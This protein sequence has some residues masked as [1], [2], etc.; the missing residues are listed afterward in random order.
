MAQDNTF[1][2]SLKDYYV[3]LSPLAY[4]DSL[5][6]KGNS[7]HASVMQNVDVLGE[8]MTQGPGL[9]NLTNG[10]QAGA[11]TE[12]INFILDKAV[13]SDV[14]YG[15]G[16]TKLFKIS[17]TAVT[18]DATF[19]HAITNCTNGESVIDMGGNLY[20]FYNKASGGEIGKYDLSSTFDDDWG[21]TTP[22]GAAAIQKAVHPSA[23]KEDII[24]FGNGQYVG[25]YI[26]GS[27]TLD[28]DKLDFGS[29]NEVADVVFSGNQWMIAVNSGVTGTNRNIGQIYLYD[30]GALSS[31]LS[32]EA[33]VGFQKIGWLYELNGIVYVAYQD[34]SSTGYTIGYISGR[35][36]KPLAHFTGSLP[37]F[38]QKTLYKHTI[39]FLS[40][41]AVWSAGA[42]IEEFP[43]SI[44]QLADGGYATVGA[45]ACPFGTPMIAS[46]DGATNFKLAKFSG[47]DVNCLWK[48]VVIPISQGR[49]KGFIDDITVL[50]K[51][52]ESG[53]SATIKLE[54]N[55]AVSSSPAQTITTT[56]K[57]RHIFRVSVPNIEDMRVFVD[58]SGGSAT[59][60]V[61]IR[62]IIIKGHYY[63]S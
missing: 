32:D 18:N 3:G 52:L 23:T 58:W 63:Q 57:T 54:Y 15:I 62:D 5:T 46:T 27:N 8:F 39:L 25:T 56:G 6:Q 7:G 38:A 48:S 31:I 13:S 12:L 47:F 42:V 16:A 22:N 61:E 20:Y 44:S 30:G 41:G 9:A 28:V 59:K 14:T 35:Q 4:L 49:N 19:P 21:S 11:V 55:Q 50:T 1:T 43:F 2:I 45:L 33:G 34:L 51:P 26:G 10:T 37:N 24:V 60:D 29:G 36:I 40:S 17:S 53:A